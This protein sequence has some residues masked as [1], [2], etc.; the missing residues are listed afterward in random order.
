MIALVFI[1]L[2]ATTDTPRPIPVDRPVAAHSSP[3]PGADREDAMQIMLTRDGRVFFG[4]QQ[5]VVTDLPD[6]IRDHVRN[7]AEKRIYL[8]ADARAKYSDVKA[9]LDEVG[10]AG[11]D[12]V[13]ILTQEPYR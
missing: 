5:I 8:A 2:P 10:R 3:M 4:N 7:G 13:S 12:K 1:F 9:V 6:E 11:L